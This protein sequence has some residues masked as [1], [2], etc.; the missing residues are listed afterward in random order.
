MSAHGTAIEW[1]QRPGT[2]GETWNPIAGCSV[3][4]PGCANCYAMRRAAPRLAGNKATPHYHGTVTGSKAGPVWT[5]KIGIASDAVLTKPLR[6]KSPRTVFVNSTSDLFHEDVP[7][8]VIDRD[9]AIM[10]LTP[11]HTYQVLTKR[12]ARM[13]EYLTRDSGDQYRSNRI[14]R[15]VLD[16]VIKKQVI[17]TDA[18][19]PMQDDCEDEWPVLAKWPLPNVWLGVSVEDQ[20]RADERIPEL[21]ATPAAKRFVSAEP[22]LGPVDFTDIVIPRLGGEQHIN[23]LYCEE[24]AEDCEDIGTGT[25][26]WIIVGGESGNGARPMHPDWARSIRDQC[27]AAGVPFF[28]KQWGEWAPNWSNDSDGNKVPG[29]EWIDRCGKRAAG[30]SLDGRQHKE[31]PA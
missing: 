6:W 17:L 2:K 1:T 5:G 29:T 27:L 22:L 4:S 21:L 23:A 31:F 18:N 12:A 16:L 15:A 28:F 30:S 26:D 14:C 13:R 9:F 8:A 20:T 19:W 3:V 25:L 10:A 7:D 24:D 11:Q